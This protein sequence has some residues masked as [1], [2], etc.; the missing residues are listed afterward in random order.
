MQKKR[1]KAAKR[2][3]K[4][5]VPK[6]KSSK[7]R[8]KPVVYKASKKE[9]AVS[10]GKPSK[11]M[12]NSVIRRGNL[13]SKKTGTYEI[14]SKHIYARRMAVLQLTFRFIKIVKG[15]RD[16]V[17]IVTSRSNK[18]FLSTDYKRAFDE[19]YQRALAQIDFS[20]DSYTIV[21]RRYFYWE[22][23]R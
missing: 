19:C 1:K 16:R 3:R 11:V 4:S 22:K 2:I 23:L 20:P 8:K 9:I 13:L 15:R 14:E 7:K 6:R 10:E 12:D 18:L 21:K 17:R 5:V